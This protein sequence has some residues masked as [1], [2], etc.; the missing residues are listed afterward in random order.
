M[1]S[2]PGNIEQ[3][4]WHLP[5]SDSAATRPHV[6]NT[7]TSQILVAALIMH[8]KCWSDCQESATAAPLIKELYETTQYMEKERHCNKVRHSV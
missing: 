6:T 5:V 2:L 1:S 3:T 7:D 8:I 4:P